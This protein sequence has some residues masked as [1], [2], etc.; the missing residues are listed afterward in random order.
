MVGIAV[1]GESGTQYQGYSM[2]ECALFDGDSVA[3]N[4]TWREKPSLEELKG[5]NVRLKFYLRNAK[6]YAFTVGKG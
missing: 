3:H 2:Q 4:V 5:K 6:L 1:L